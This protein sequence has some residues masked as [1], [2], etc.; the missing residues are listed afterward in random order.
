MNKNPKRLFK[1]F[2]ILK[3]YY[4]FLIFIVFISNLYTQETI[5]RVTK[6]RGDVQLKS[7]GSGNFTTTKPGG[8]IYSGDII[9]VGK[10]GFCMVI[11]LDDKS[12]LKIR[13]DT[14]FQF[15]DTENTRTIDINFGKI[16]IDVKKDKKKDFRVETPVS[17]ASVKGTQFWS[18]I[19][20]MGFDKFYGLEGVLDIFNTISGQSVTLGP[21]QMTLS[22]ATGQVLSTPADPEEIP[23]DPENEPTEEIQSEPED[24]QLQNEDQDF[25]E[26]DDSSVQ[27][28]IPAEENLDNENME[29]ENLFEEEEE[30]NEILSDTLNQTNDTDETTP[31]LPKPFGMGLGVGSATIDGKIFN[32]LALRPEINL[33]KLGIGLDLV[34]YVDNDGNIRKDEWDETTDLLDKFLYIR[35]AEKSDPIWFKIGSLENITLGYGGL[36]SGYSNMMEFPTVRRVGLNTGLNLNR[37][38][39]ELFLAN[40]KDFVRGGTILGLRGTFTVSENIPLTLGVSYVTDM[41]QFSGL[42]DTDDDTYPD[43]FDDF[44]DST[45]LWNDTDRDGLPDP[46]YGLDS[47]RWDIDA[48][49]DNIYDQLDDSLSLKPTPFSIEKNKS[50][51]NGFTLDIGYPIVNSESFSLLVYSEFNRLNFPL[52]DSEQ[53]S[54][55]ERSG[56]GFTVPGLRGTILKFITFSIEYRIKNDY[57]LPKFFDQAYDLNRILPIYSDAGTEVFTKD[58]LVFADSTTK[59]NTKGYYGSLGFDFLNIANFKASYA[60]MVADTIKFRSFN[61]NI[62]VNTENIPKLSVAQAFFQRNNDENPF[63]FENP[64]INTVLGYRLGYEVAKGVSVVWNYKQFYRDKGTG[65]EPIKQTTI[66]T[67]FDF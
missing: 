42:K 65:L 67:V 37:F 34:L 63:D 61:T 8:P 29:I 50:I 39:S 40:I 20:Q 14:Q 53:F 18:I 33:G 41:N 47:S 7:L 49:G 31:D 12:I 56:T 13:E 22:T 48:D 30:T 21:G 11:Y 17:V 24:V 27:E 43:I 36:L 15:M 60:N 64:T 58:M 51:A 54:R 52:V 46:H 3:N 4:L 6:L 35:W 2:L 1:V 32:Q 16:L 44:P 10:E 45:K 62:N 38:G 55:T 59:I 25:Q 66:E 19:N 57:F 9:N 5:A 26:T 28:D 23:V